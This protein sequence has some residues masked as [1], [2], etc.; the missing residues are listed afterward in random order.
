[1]IE[2]RSQSFSQLSMKFR[3]QKNETQSKFKNLKFTQTIIIS[4]IS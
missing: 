4:K 1:M 2:K 3:Q